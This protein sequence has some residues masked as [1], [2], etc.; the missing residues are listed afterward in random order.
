MLPTDPV[1]TSAAKVQVAPALMLP[2]VMPNVLPPP[3]A[4]TVPPHENVALGGDLS[5]IPAGN[6][7][8]KATL[9]KA[10]AVLNG[11]G[12]ARRAAWQ[13]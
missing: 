6:A 4:L 10:I 8:V 9:V 11:D 13:Y 5:V 2:P 1:V 7:S 3:V 12:Q